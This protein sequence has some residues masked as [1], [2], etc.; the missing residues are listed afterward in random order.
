[1]Q[2][3][4]ISIAAKYKRATL[5]TLGKKSI[6]V[7]LELARGRARARTRASVSMNY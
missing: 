3:S 6:L 2:L 1:V 5:F 4:C 7:G